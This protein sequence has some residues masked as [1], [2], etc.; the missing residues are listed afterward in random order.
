MPWYTQTNVYG[1]ETTYYSDPI[2]IREGEGL[3]RVMREPLDWWQRNLFVPIMNVP[4]PRYIDKWDIFVEYP[5]LEELDYNR[6]LFETSHGIKARN[7]EWLREAQQLEYSAHW[8]FCC[9]PVG[10]L[11]NAAMGVTTHW[12]WRRAFEKQLPSWLKYDHPIYRS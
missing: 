8:E 2:K 6:L 4:V 5:F 3:R 7:D 9:W 12:Q 1:K 10:C 11:L